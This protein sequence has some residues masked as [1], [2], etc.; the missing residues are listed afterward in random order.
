RV[1]EPFFS[2]KVSGEGLGLGLAISQA[3]VTEFGGG[4]EIASTLGSGT[5]ITV[6]LPAAHPLQEAAE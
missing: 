4:I 6:S 2:T 1:T 3:I 5:V